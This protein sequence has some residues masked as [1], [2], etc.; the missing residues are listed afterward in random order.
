MA[1]YK[2]LDDLESMINDLFDR[3]LLRVK[4]CG[5]FRGIIILLC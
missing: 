4:V 1:D 2:D 3:V 5:K